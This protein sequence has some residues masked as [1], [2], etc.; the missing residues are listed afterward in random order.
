MPSGHLDPLAAPSIR[1]SIGLALLVVLLCPSAVVV[2]QT[3]DIGGFVK[4]SY[5]YDTRQIVGAREGDFVLYPQPVDLVEGEDAN[6][7]DNLL[8]FPLF[9]RLTFTVGDLPDVLG[10][11]VTGRVEG[12]FHGASN[13]VLNSYRLR[14]GYVKFAWDR[15][16]ALFGM[17]WSPTFLET[18]PRTAATEAGVPYHSFSRLP[19]VRWTYRPEGFKVM[20]LAAQERDAF[21]ELSGLKTAQQAGLPM[22]MA[23][24]GI[25]RETLRLGAGAWTKWVRPTLDGDRFHAM[26]YQGYVTWSPAPFTFRA[27]VTYGEDL[28]DQIMTGGF[29]V[30]DDGDAVSLRTLGTWS[31]IETNRERLN[32][33]LFGGWFTNLGAGETVDIADPVPA[34]GDPARNVFARGFMIDRGFRVAPRATYD[35]GRVRFALELQIDD[36]VYASALDEEFAPAPTDDDDSVTNVRTDFSVFLFF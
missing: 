18:W 13:D 20:V 36:V 21:A 33:G 26:A 23:F 28:A 19:Q 22:I 12:D 32:F 7:T 6:A 29:V 14:R 2:A 3:V 1:R 25:E 4:S 9:S 5:Y 34:A 11:E 24:A 16:E 31:E 30:D 17:E 8:F 35:V 27:K 15:H 10:A